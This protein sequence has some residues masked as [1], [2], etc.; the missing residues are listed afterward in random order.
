MSYYLEITPPA[1]FSMGTLQN[2]LDFDFDYKG[3]FCYT[4]NFLR[5]N[6]L[7]QNVGI[8]YEIILSHVDQRVKVESDKL[9][10]FRNLKAFLIIAV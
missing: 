9:N 4:F 1:G 6:L 8:D 10:L 3:L 2:Y 5:Q 7:D